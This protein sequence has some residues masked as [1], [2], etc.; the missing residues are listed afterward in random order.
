MSGIDVT[1]DK[2]E[3]TIIYRILQEI[4]TNIARHSK[5]NKVYC[6]IKQKDGQFLL[7]ATDNGV[8]FEVKDRYDD[9]FIRPYGDA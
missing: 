9:I 6:F 2:N 4:L 7:V 1:F 3:T 5:A 8:G